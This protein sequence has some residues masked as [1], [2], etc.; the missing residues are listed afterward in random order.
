MYQS[1]IVKEELFIKLSKLKNLSEVQ[2]SQIM[3]QILS[4]I[5][6]CYERNV[7]H[8]DLKPHNILL[9]ESN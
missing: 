2:A 4:A 5:S 1:S 7:I 3:L 8:P 6:Y 9:E